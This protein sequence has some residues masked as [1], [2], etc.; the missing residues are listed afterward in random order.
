MSLYFRL[1]NCFTS[2]TF[3]SAST[4]DRNTDA[5]K[6]PYAAL[7]FSIIMACAA[8]MRTLWFALRRRQS[9]SR[10][11]PTHVRFAPATKRPSA[12][13]L[14]RTCRLWSTALLHGAGSTPG[15]SPASSS[16][17]PMA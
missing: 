16:M 9:C 6:S 15:R 17:A 5:N 3:R 4:Y 12:V 7:V 14:Q 1:L 2:S 13:I 10:D 8:A 11:T